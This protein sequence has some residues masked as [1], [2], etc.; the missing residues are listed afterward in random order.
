MLK[1][2]AIG[3]TGYVLG[4]KAGRKRYDQINRAYHAVVESPVTK[5]AIETGRR[6]LAQKLDPQHGMKELRRVEPDVTVLE[7]KNRWGE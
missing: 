1:W 7:P 6:A 4:A 2:V 3:A 5:K